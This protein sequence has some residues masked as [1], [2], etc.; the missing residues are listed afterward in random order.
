MQRYVMQPLSAF[1]QKFPHRRILTRR[2]QQL[3]TAVAH[4]DHRRPYLFVLD[5]PFM[6]DAKT[7]RLVEITSGGNALHRNSQMINLCHDF[8]SAPASLAA[9][10][11]HKD[12]PASSP[13]ALHARPIPLQ[14]IHAAGLP[15][16]KLAASSPPYA[17]A[18]TRASGLSGGHLQKASSAFCQLRRSNPQP[19]LLWKPRSAPPAES[20]FHDCQL[21]TAS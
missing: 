3:H 14:T 20:N 18:S 9:T 17:R 8:L 2:L 10:P 21:A 11:A 1:R 15:A 13:L 12:L 4:R 7:Q 6:C 5:G 19:R 16:A